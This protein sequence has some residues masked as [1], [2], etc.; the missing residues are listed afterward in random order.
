MQEEAER[1]RPPPGRSLANGAPHGDSNVRR[2]TT[3]RVSREIDP[4]AGTRRSRARLPGDGEGP[5]A[6]PLRPRMRLRAGTRSQMTP[7]AIRSGAATV[8]A[9]ALGIPSLPCVTCIRAC[10][11]RR[12][13]LA[14]HSGPRHRHHALCRAPH[15]DARHC[16]GGCQDGL[17]PADEPHTFQGLP[18]PPRVQEKR[19]RAPARRCHRGRLGRI[20]VAR[21]HDLGGGAGWVAPWVHR[22]ES[23]STALRRP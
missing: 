6:D 2:S 8:G 22:L 23:S 17:G 19:T 11:W 14:A 7:T 4:E 9:C 1:R 21:C 10:A 15:G 16:H 3:S 5:G 20:K 18:C 13:G 12:H